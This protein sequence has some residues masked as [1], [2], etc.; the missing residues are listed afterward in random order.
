MCIRDRLRVGVGVSLGLS[1]R[2]SARATIYVAVFGLNVFLMTGLFNPKSLEFQSCVAICFVVYS[3]HGIV[4]GVSIVRNHFLS[5]VR[6][7]EVHN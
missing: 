2:P 6:S 3:S 1:I 4:H 7:V 5:D